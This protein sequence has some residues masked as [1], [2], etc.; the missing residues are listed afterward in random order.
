[1]PM[2]TVRT[3]P[4]TVVSEAMLKL[5]ALCCGRLNFDR[6][7]FFPDD[8]SGNKLR[9][10]VP[11]FLVIHPKGK[12]LFDTGIDC[13]AATDPI[14]HLGARLAASFEIAAAPDEHAA[15]QLAHFGLGC[16]DI[17]TVANSH[18]H[19]DHCGCNALFPRAQFLV[20]RNELA[21]ARAP[22]SHAFAPGWDHALDYRE[23]D[24]EHDVFG[25]ASVILFPTPGH[26]QGHQS[27]KVQVSKGRWI[28]M[29]AD[30]CYTQEHLDRDLLP[31]VA[32]NGSLMHETMA[33]FRQMGERSD[34]EL[35]FGHDADQWLR[36][37]ERTHAST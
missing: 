29:T 25:D 11:G 37:P 16:D 31:V 26:T 1:M 3:S 30:A 18:L 10:P 20:Q 23:L 36:L 21:A 22:K 34:T 28:V 5:H 19:F 32:W 27:L 4:L 15:G 14:A 24:G 2:S 8:N 35:I 17:N 6:K 12:L 33:K 9:A 7:V 13:R